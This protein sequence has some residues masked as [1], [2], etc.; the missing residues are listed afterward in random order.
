MASALFERKRLLEQEAQHRYGY[1]TD[2]YDISIL[3]RGSA[4]G[5]KWVIMQIL[6][7]VRSERSAGPH[8]DVHGHACMRINSRALTR[9]QSAERSQYILCW[10]GFKKA[11][12]CLLL[13]SSCRRKIHTRVRRRAHTPTRD[14]LLILKKLE[15]LC[16]SS[17]RQ[18]SAG[19]LHR[20]SE[21]SSV[22][23][24][25]THF[26][27]AVLSVETC[28]WNRGSQGGILG[29][30]QPLIVVNS[31]WCRCCFGEQSTFLINT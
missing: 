18:K 2:S 24:K 13:R 12:W 26:M 3:L 8:A 1:Q 5:S 31:Y 21:I 25:H 19:P 15:Q 11:M 27:V 28:V 29:Q 10:G 4:G 16:F 20:R 23:R 9:R 14:A 30:R 7:N 6:M 17:M 22:Y